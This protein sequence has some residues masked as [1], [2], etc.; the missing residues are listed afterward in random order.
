MRRFLFGLLVA[1]FP[2]VASAQMI[3]VKSVPVAEGDQF[4]LFPSQSLSMGGVS[5]AL[6]DPLHD[7]FANPAKGRRLEGIRFSSSPSYYSYL[8]EGSSEMS[9]RTLPV[10]TM[11][12]QGN[13]FGGA[14]LALQELTAPEQQRVVPF[15]PEVAFRTTLHLEEGGALPKNNL[16]GFGMAG[17][18]V[19]DTRL[20][21]GASAFAASLSR[22]GGVSWLYRNGREV[23][24][25]GHLQRFRVG[26]TYEW[27]DG[28]VADLVA[29]HHRIDMTHTM[30]RW[31][32]T[33][34]GN[35]AFQSHEEYDKTVGWA[36][37][38]GYRQPLNEGWHLGGQLTGNWKRHPKIPNYDLM[39]IPRDPGSSSAYQIG[40]GVA[41]ERGSA[42]YGLD[43]I[44]EPIWSHTWA[45]A[46]EDTET[47]SGD[48]VEAGDMTVE[49]F[50]RFR[51][52]RL[53]MGVHQRIGMIDFS[54]GLNLHHIRYHL[55]QED[56]VEEFE[57]ELDESWTEWTLSG[58]LGVHLDAFQ[59]RYLGRL[60]LGTG[61]PGVTSSRNTAEFAAQRSADFVVAPSG[62]LSLREVTVLTHRVSVLVPL[63]D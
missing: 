1:F 36:V 41:R 3:P 8:G 6:D 13:V 5:I 42:R 4:L 47:P 56:F 45:N 52:A 49:N 28:R 50:F 39:Q 57:R 23:E 12:R 26:A 60:K 19:P 20:S 33:E 63:S 30:E 61:Q 32:V 15:R 14:V 38:A 2:V 21:V 44:Y 55:D 35:G 25:S 29:L 37:R 58:G 46:L 59:V 22:L 24:Q 31:V 7:P 53:R 48:V 16:Y 17:L 18:T 9:G 62:P 11:A 34:D 27:K 51:N 54:L 43:L 10:G 40:M